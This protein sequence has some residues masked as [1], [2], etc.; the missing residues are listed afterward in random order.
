MQSI[1]VD[2]AQ[3]V[4]TIT[5]NRPEVRNAIDSTL[6]TEVSEAIDEA[7]QLDDIHAI[8]VTGAGR[9]FCAGMDLNAF[10]RGERPSIPGRGLCGIT[11]HEP[12]LPLLAA[13]E[14]AAVGGGFEIALTADLLIAATDARF[15]LPEVRRGLVATQG[16]A[17]RLGRRLPHPIAAEMLL[18]GRMY[19]AADL[20][21][22]GLFTRLVE[23]GQALSTAQELGRLISTMAPLAL[24]ATLE[25]LR[26]QNTPSPDMWAHQDTWFSPVLNST[27]AREGATAFVEHRRPR[28]QGR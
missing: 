16:G 27:D 11:R 17:L 20:A 26:Q 10:A 7:E 22:T 2:D 5:F 12:R 1:L 21:G 28:W 24:R 14:G 23:P 19:T 4:R 15:A 6:S 18:T 13:V 3:G 9:A 8:V 25:V